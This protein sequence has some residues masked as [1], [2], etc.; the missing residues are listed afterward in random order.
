[1]TPRPVRVFA[2]R[3]PRGTLVRVGQSEGKGIERI[4]CRSPGLGRFGDILAMMLFGMSE[5]GD[6]EPVRRGGG[7]E[8]R[9]R[10]PLGRAHVCKGISVENSL[11]GPH[12]ARVSNDTPMT[13]RRSRKREPEL[14]PAVRAALEPLVAKSLRKRITPQASILADLGLDSLKVVELT[15]LLEKELG[16]PVF[17][18]EWIASVNDPAELTVESLALFLT[19]QK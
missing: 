6:D 17:L 15:V 19:E 3:G 2:L 12:P 14:F 10:C 7:E 4:A 9:P 8:Q 18:P 16:R 1:M 11:Q 13:A 5:P